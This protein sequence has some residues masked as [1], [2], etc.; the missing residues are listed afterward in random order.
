MLR[1]LRLLLAWLVFAGCTLFFV[2]VLP[3]PFPRLQLVP[4]L[5]GAHIPLVQGVLLLTWLFGRVYCS[6]LCPLGILQDV[7]LWLR[8]RRGHKTMFRYRQELR[9]LRYGILLLF[10][11]ALFSGAAIVPV[12]LDPYSIY[13]RMVVHFFSPIWQ[14]GTSSLAAVGENS[15]LYSLAGYDIVWQ[16]AAALALSAAWFF[17]LALLVWRYGRL[18]CNTICPVGT[19]LGTI[20]RH[21]RFTVQID[22][23]KC[24]DCGLCE[25]SCRAS[26]I[27][28]GHHAVDMS[29]CLECFDCIAD[30]P[31]LP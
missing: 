20:S 31:A 24:A 5:L 11:T 18:Y 1:K 2:N 26:C 27:D 14:Y 17:V 23:A 8:R 22:K 30:C 12:M 13:G 7:I 6:M 4:A 29:R 21:A 25:R 9:G 3:L 19:L 10:G 16:G 28:V 15:G